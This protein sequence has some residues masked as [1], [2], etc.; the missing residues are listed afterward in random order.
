MKLRHKIILIVGGLMALGLLAAPPAMAVLPDEMLDDPA[1][2]ARA[3]E[4]SKDIRCLVCQ[5]ESIDDS[6]AD[7]ARDL[8][9]IVRERLVA[10]DSNAEVKQYLVDRYGEYVLLTPPMKLETLLLWGG[11]FV[12]VVIGVVA[13]LVWFRGRAP[14]PS[15]DSGAQKAGGLSAEERQRIDALLADDDEDAGEVPG[16]ASGDA[17]G[18]TPRGTRV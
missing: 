5:N 15:A 6:N 18:G 4:I 11:P 13:V 2:E 10:G 1:L 16:G 7:L 8:R 17:S 12:F 3:R 9:I 14:S